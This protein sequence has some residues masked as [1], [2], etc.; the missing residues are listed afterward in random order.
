MISELLKPDELKDNERVL[1]LNRVI[2]R[3][4][5]LPSVEEEQSNT[6]FN[7]ETKKKLQDMLGVNVNNETTNM[8][9]EIVGSFEKVLTNQSGGNPLGGIMEISQMISVKY[10][11]KINKG[12]NKKCQ[13]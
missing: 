12:E 4:R 6:N 8:I 13:F 2:Y 1:Q 5:E 7:Q 10:A 11:D 9:D 3:E